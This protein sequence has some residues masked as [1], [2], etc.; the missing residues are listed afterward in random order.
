ML[1]QQIAQENGFLLIEEEWIEEIGSY[2]RIYEHIKSGARLI[3]LD[4]E[5]N[6][7]VFTASFKTLPTN[8]TGVAHIVEH[9]VCC[10][11]KKYPLKDTFMEL[12]K[13]SLNTSL[14]AC[15]YKDMT[16][17]YCASQNEKD[18]GNLIEVYLDLIFHPLIHERLYLFKQ[19]G[20]RYSIEDAESPL[21][22]TGIVYN[23]MNGEY[24]EP[25]TR[26][27]HLIHENLFPDT[28]YKYDS[29]GKPEEIVK[30]DEKA[31]LSFYNTYYKP[32]NCT[33]FLYG[34]CDLQARLKQLDEVL[35]AFVKEEIRA[36]IPLQKPFETLKMCQGYYPIEAKE[37]KE[38]ALLALTF[39]VG[40]IHNVTLRLAFEMLEH[41][42]LKSPASPL[43]EVLLGKKSI[44]KS[45][46]ES[47]YD[48]GKRQPT[49]SIILN[50]THKA[51][52]NTFKKRIFNVF[53]KLVKE[54][55][56]KDLIDAA[57]NTVTF[58]L[59]EGDTP[60]EAKGVILSE[61]VQMGVLYDGHPFS[62]LK[63]EK[64]LQEIAEQKDKGY[65][66]QIIETYFLNNSHAVCALLEPDEK[67]YEME[68]IKFNNELEAYKQ[69][70]TQE[71]LT[72]LILASET[73]EDLQEQQNAIEDLEKLPHL[74]LEDLPNHPK[75]PTFTTSQEEGIT[76][77]WHHLDTQDIAY[78]HV[79]FDV[80]SVSQK[81][82]NYLG[83][84]S[85]L[86]TYVGTTHYSYHALENAINKETGGLN[87]SVQAYAE[88]N[89]THAFKPYLKISLKVLMSQL[90]SLPHLL[91][92]IT[93][94]TQFNDEM[95]V[96]ELIDLILYEMER[97]FKS[98]PEYR[99]TRTL[100]TY[101]SQAA[102]YEDYVSGM[103]YYDF[104]KALKVELIEDRKKG[105]KRLVE[106]LE[107]L[108]KQI[109]QRQDLFVS[110]TAP[111]QS[112]PT[113]KNYLEQFIGCLP[114]QQLQKVTYQ[115]EPEIKNQ[116]FYTATG[117]QAITMGGNFKDL[118]FNFTGSLY[119]LNHILDS[120]YLWDKVR[121]QGGAYGAQLTLGRDGN[122]VF[123][124]S[125]DPELGATLEAFNEA[126][127]FI[128]KL[129]LSLKELE[130]CIIGT[131]GG[132]TNPLTMEQKSEQ[133]LIYGLTHVTKDIIEKEWQEVL[134][135]T[136]EDLRNCADLVEAVCKL[137][138]T[139]VIG[140]RTKIM[141]EASRFKSIESL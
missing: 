21:S 36:D 73:L 14:N 4:N 120:T 3:Q 132:L 126:V 131:I 88:C 90:E 30:L 38:E 104:L 45:I 129:D 47:G 91:E 54:G 101:G 118:G 12:D 117:V 128:Q 97:S 9:T 8:N 34:K 33:F 138:G 11:S 16:M 28:C 80:A 137:N 31:F 86:L 95:K 19:E 58:S 6:H 125:C 37:E 74:S 103:I 2:A 84:L 109:I 43:Y 20:W 61:E 105:F 124:S 49:F 77:Q 119:V 41:M 29:G 18:F 62:H 139:C 106:N 69:S 15:T 46:D 55:I 114:V 111:A 17:Y 22:Y 79:L 108:Y 85:N 66:E 63:Y 115:F 99:A 136:I 130:R 72:K 83:L 123:C 116:A 53:K 7:Q 13:G 110:V 82:L 140:N 60:W 70:L 35:Q 71:G 56:S 87:C 39:V 135:T 5:D 51:H 40:E 50:G 93:C 112:Q 24:M 122:M 89:N 42:L 59:K 68:E 65:F 94:H 32:S 25:S 52:H 96:H 98:T 113:V 75:Y 78:I 23:E 67:Q 134:N 127:A 1:L 102:I 81:D 100:Y 133:V 44:G 121:L 64:A 57:F 48:T 26:L 141:E 92:E 27:E 10:A 107:R 76:W